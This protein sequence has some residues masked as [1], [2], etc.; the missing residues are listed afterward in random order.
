VGSM[1]DD[2][3]AMSDVLCCLQGM[4][5][6]VDK[7]DSNS[8]VPLLDKAVKSL[9]TSSPAVADLARRSDRTA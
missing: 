5:H 1:L 4:V 8:T 3:K 6:N 9:E 2:R 7:A